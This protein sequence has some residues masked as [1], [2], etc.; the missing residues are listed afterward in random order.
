MPT[1]RISVFW[2]LQ[3]K[4]LPAHPSSFFDC[5]Q[6]KPKPSTPQGMHKWILG[7][8]IGDHRGSTKRDYTPV[9]ENKTEGTWIM[10]WNIKWNLCLFRVYLEVCQIRGTL[11]GVSIT[12]VVNFWGL[13]WGLPVC[14]YYHTIWMPYLILYEASGREGGSDPK[15]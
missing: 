6:A 5:F 7:T 2:G 1:T 11:L 3:V 8:T 12:T 9:M 10:R 14:G 15:P 13:F 4:I